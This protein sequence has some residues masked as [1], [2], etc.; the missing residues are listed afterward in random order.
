MGWFGGGCKSYSPQKASDGL[1]RAT[2]K[3]KYTRLELKIKW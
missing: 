1:K 2:N 3:V